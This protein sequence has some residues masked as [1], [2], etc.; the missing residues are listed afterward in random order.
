MSTEPTPAKPRSYVRLAIGFLI[1]G[2][3]LFWALSKLDL[4]AAGKILVTAKPEWIVLA[5]AGLMSGYALRAYRW[6]LM[7][8][9][10]GATA[11]YGAA[12]RVFL[13]AVAMNNV[14]PFR[15]GD[16]S[17]AVSFR[18]ELGATTPQ[19]LGTMVVERILDFLSLLFVFFLAL[20][21]VQ[22]A[23]IPASYIS[24]VKVLTAVL[25]V[26]LVG[27]LLFA[28]PVR[29]RIETIKTGPV[30]RFAEVLVRFLVSVEAVA[31]LSRLMPLV[32]LSLPAWLLESGLF[33]ATAHSL[34]LDVPIRGPMLSMATGTLATL[35]PSTPGYVGTFDAATAQGIKAFGI[36]DTP[37][38][39]YALLAHVVLWVPL[40]AVG[41]ALVSYMSVQ[42]TKPKGAE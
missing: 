33:I 31:P 23:T 2:G 26:L 39:V 8:R 36:A 14:L 12:Y 22:A 13:A 34:G 18:D 20:T 5:V 32:A 3:F 37:A 42:R 40:T 6:F 9:S 7:L 25:V 30:A 10:V 24:T 17:R 29:R 21:G 11:S 35:I 28:G 27:L 38:T 15:A 1:G 19:I 4:A 41:F 16:V